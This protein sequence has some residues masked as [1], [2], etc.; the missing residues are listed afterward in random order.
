M[1]L[2]RHSIEPSPRRA[3]PSWTEFLRQ[4]AQSLVAC[5]FFTADT[6]LLRRLYVLFFIEIDTRRVCVTGVTA[7]PVGSWVVQQAQI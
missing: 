5:D 3:D 4:Q 6:V 1:I 2:R 7:D